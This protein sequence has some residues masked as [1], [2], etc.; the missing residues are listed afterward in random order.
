MSR[1]WTKEQLD[2]IRKEGTNII[3]S[4]GAG[5]GKTAVL[6]ER[7]IRKLKQGVNINKLLVL[8]FTKAAA[9]EMKERIRKSLI[10]DES[11]KEQLSLLDSSYITTFDSFALSVVKKY[12]YLLNISS[13]VA[14]CDS[15]LLKMEKKAIIDNIF[16]EL[17]MQENPY[18]L[19]LISDFCVKDDRSIK[20]Y[21][22]KIND[23]LDMKYDRDIYLDT[24]ISVFFN[25]LKIETD[26]KDFIKVIQDRCNSIEQL[27][28][29]I[30]FYVESD[31]YDKL[32]TSL[33][34][35]LNSSNYNEYKSN[36]NIN[37]P[38][39]PNNTDDIVKAYR[40]NI[41]DIIKEI[42]DMCLWDNDLELKDSII[43]TKE[44]IDIIIYIIKEFDKRLKK[45][46]D[47]KNVYEFNDIANLSIKLIKEN[48]NIKNELKNTFHEILVDEYQDTNDL[49]EGFVSLISNNNVYMVGDIKQS[50]YRFRNANP[51]IF[52]HKYERYKHSDEGIKIDLN[53]NFRSRSEV[54]NNINLIFDSLMDLT[55]GG[56]DYKKEHRLESGNMLYLNEGK[57]DQNNN[58]E[59]YNYTYDKDLGFKKEELEIFLI[60]NDIRNKIDNH[61]QV[62]DKDKGILRTVT[63]SDF[64]ILLDRSNYFDLYKKIFTYMKIPIIIHK[65]DSIAT[66]SDILVVKSILKLINYCSRKQ[67][68]NDFKYAFM[69]VGR[70]FLFEYND[71]DLFDYITNDNYKETKLYQKAMKISEK[72]NA[73]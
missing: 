10:G 19:K 1:Q 3:V 57:T 51:N 15:A 26:I 39:L 61:Y 60:A 40:D 16:D 41:K 68:D 28:D 65:E 66:T 5:S 23:K 46:K 52:M 12:H 73:L 7:V 17:Y 18:Y 25:D 50:I 58:L 67:F 11:L 48:D 70:S 36:L 4:A 59:I 8:T 71:N 14:I 32:E 49:Q 44:Y 21:I 47:C 45:Y 64:A 53:K 38:R 34:P 20:E 55:L 29:K 35:L 30:S 33:S 2:A 43:K 54:L 22:L 31:Y 24:Y 6:T 42:N 37:F 56:A 9:H 27:L 13:N 62:M 63:Y 69:S 72:L